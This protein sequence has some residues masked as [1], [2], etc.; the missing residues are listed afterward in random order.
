LE[1]DP[2]VLAEIATATTDLDTATDALVA[3]AVASAKTAAADDLADY[4]AA[5]GSASDDVYTN[6]AAATTVQGVTDARTAL[7]AA[8][9]VLLDAIA[10]AAAVDVI[11]AYAAGSN[12]DAMT[13]AQLVAAGVTGTAE[14]KLAAYKT[15]IAAALATA[16]DT[17]AEIQTIIDTV[18]TAAT[19]ATP[20]GGGGVA[21]VVPPT[22]VVAPTPVAAPQITRSEA[23]AANSAKLSKD[24]RV[25]IREAL[26]SNPNAKS[27]VCRGFVASGTATAAD[28][29]LARDRSTAVCNL[30]TKLNPDLDVEVKKV[31][32]ASSSKQLR[33]VRMI[34]R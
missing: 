24:L 16:A 33:K 22:P 18:N 28:R 19:P 10:L 26:A 29:K 23:F 15:A 31:V 21:T 6:V 12:A 7:T 1:A 3:T 32:V 17:T 5:G 34:L 9:Q 13:I 25:G 20:S 11:E 30:I 27:A 2:Q 8:T 4:V 14:G